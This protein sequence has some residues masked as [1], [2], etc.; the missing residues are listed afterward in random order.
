MSRCIFDRMN[1]LPAKITSTCFPSERSR[2][3]FWGKRY[4]ECSVTCSL[5]Y[6]QNELYLVPTWKKST[7]ECCKLQLWIYEFSSLEFYK[8][9]NWNT[10]ILKRNQ[11][12]ASD[13]GPRNWNPLD[14]N[15]QPSGTL[16]EGT[17]RGS[18]SH[19]VQAFWTKGRQNQ[20]RTQIMNFI[21]FYQDSPKP[22]K[23]KISSKPSKKL[24]HFQSLV[25]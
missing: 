7:S 14:W 4:I 22:F 18:I 2:C 17:V 13:G 20:Q 6:V 19:V 24:Y 8:K 10:Q 15:S 25:N 12:S 3:H 21:S 5:V 1:I 16:A 9:S 11:N 23:I